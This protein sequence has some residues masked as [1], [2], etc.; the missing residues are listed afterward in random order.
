MLICEL[1]V[2]HDKKLAY[3]V[4]FLLIYWTDFRNCM[5]SHLVQMI[6]LELVF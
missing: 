3:S 1:L 2:R 5:K 4:E 6:D